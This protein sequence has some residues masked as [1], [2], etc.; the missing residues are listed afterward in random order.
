MSTVKGT[1]FEGLEPPPAARL[2]GWTLIGLDEQEGTIEV[3]FDGKPEFANP[4]GFVQGGMLTAMLD[5]AMGP[6]LLVASKGKYLATTIDLHVHFLRPV[7][8][9]PIRVKART[10]QIGRNI[11]F[12][13]ATLFDGKGR[14]CARTTAS[15]ALSESPFKKAD[16]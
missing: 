13:E 1:M 9:G 12:L 16:Q 4:A 2:L 3:G 8:V 14:A 6:A 7:P 11:A 10:T 5:D 15:A